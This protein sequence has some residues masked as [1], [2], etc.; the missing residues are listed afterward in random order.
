MSGSG[1]WGS[2]ETEGWSSRPPEQG[3]GLPGLHS[4]AQDGAGLT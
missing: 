4:T 1:A 3:R 2:R